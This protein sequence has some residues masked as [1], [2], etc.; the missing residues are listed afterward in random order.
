MYF[1]EEALDDKDLLL[2]NIRA[3]K[4]RLIARVLPPTADLESDS[5]TVVWDIV[6]DRG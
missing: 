2:Q 3:N 5:L 6:L 1:P 4:D